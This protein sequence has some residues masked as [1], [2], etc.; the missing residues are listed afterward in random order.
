MIKID[1]PIMFLGA[2]VTSVSL[3]GNWGSRSS[4]CN[5][6]LVEQ[7]PDPSG[8]EDRFGNVAD[9]KKIGKKIDDIQFAP[10][11]GYPTI[12]TACKLTIEDPTGE[13]EPFVFVGTLQRWG[14]EED[15]SAGRKYDVT[16]ESPGEFLDNVHVILNKWHGYAYTSDL[17]LNPPTLKPLFTYASTT[18][19]DDVVRDVTGK[20][21][22]DP[23]TRQ[24][25]PKTGILYTPSN[26]INLFAY[27][28]NVQ[29]GGLN[30]VGGKFGASDITT[31]GYPLATI[32]EDMRDCCNVKLQ[33][34]F[35][36]KLTLSE[37]EYDLDLSGFQ[38]AMKEIGDL[39]VEGDTS[40]LT[41]IIDLIAEKSLHNYYVYIDEPLYPVNPPTANEIKLGVMREASIKFKLITRK[42]PLEPKAIENLVKEYLRLDS[43]ARILKSYKL[44]QE[45]TSKL[46]TQ[47]MIIGGP[48][49]RTWV[50]NKEHILP[51]WGQKGYGKNAFYYY[52][53]SV[54]EYYNMFSPITV[55]ADAISMT[56]ERPTTTNVQEGD[57]LSY[58]TNLLEMRLALANDRNAWNIYH[59]L[60][61]LA[62]KE[63]EIGGYL[64]AF[65]ETYN[66]NSPIALVA[67]FGSFNKVKDLEQIFDG[68]NSTHDLMDTSFQSAEIRT[69]YM[70]GTKDAQI[71]Y[72]Q[73]AINTRWNAISAVAKT[74]YGRQFLVAVPSEPGGVENNFRWNVADQEPNYVWQTT[75][76]AWA[77]E[78]IIDYIPDASFYSKGMGDLKPTVTYPLFNYEG[79]ASGGIRDYSTAVLADYS[80]FGSQYAV[81]DY[82]SKPPSGAWDRKAITTYAGGLRI[83]QEWGTRYFDVTK[84][85]IDLKGLP[86]KNKVTGKITKTNNVYGFV[87]VDVPPVKVYD[88]YT[89]QVNAFGVLAQL[90]FRD[91]SLIGKK[92]RVGYYNMFGSENVVDNAEIPPSMMPPM[93]ISIPQQSTRYVWGPWWAFSDFSGIQK[94]DPKAKPDEKEKLIAAADKKAREARK[95]TLSFE[96]KPEITPE[97]FGS[98]AI[99]Y[100][101][102]QKLCT[103]DLTKL[104][105]AE[106][107][108]IELAQFPKFK[109]GDALKNGPA[110]KDMSIS[111][112]DAGISTTYSFTNWTDVDRSQMSKYNFSRLM[113]ANRL[114]FDKKSENDQAIAERRASLKP[115]NETLLKSMHQLRFDQLKHSNNGVFCSMQNTMWRSLNQPQP[116]D[117]DYDKYPVV[118]AHSS[119]TESAMKS[120][121]LSPEES[122]GSSFEQSHS[123]AYIWDQRF[124]EAH[125]VLFNEGIVK[126]FDNEMPPYPPP[127]PAPTAGQ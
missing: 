60:F 22:I 110:I 96:V 61:A 111:I 52:G 53:N 100:T 80:A 13:S 127:P 109:L 10:A 123:P 124:P 41:Q 55:T 6:T 112:S 57:F 42:E 84:M 83:D 59:K 103:A 79:Y 27:K 38:D 74:M 56:R 106:T 36:G 93:L 21:K 105:S 64:P 47:K 48:A 113:A 34:P 78:Q 99:M 85:K 30:A 43:P 104:H 37:T 29:K 44:G 97:V 72:L 121:G 66:Y 9:P 35:G 7:N 32:L 117:K 98:T 88:E 67:A 116:G 94:I 25:Y 76:S 17:N 114:K 86:E 8:V 77:G 28:E 31:Q 51:I 68:R 15:P 125:K 40:T 4:Q 58:Q 20:A 5:I 90:I 120:I 26:V 45:S 91:N 11:T 118:N 1:E 33:H 65:Y 50:A 2:Y 39:R 82:Q 69:S 75:G 101:E 16:L 92:A 71:D 54:D 73:R 12:G 3:N 95:G 87:K 18:Q 122:F 89:T 49:S 46:V 14:Y 62:L 23:V 81:I 126:G 19:E 63:A 119:S 24:L 102:M 115:V 107:G 70:F 108:Y